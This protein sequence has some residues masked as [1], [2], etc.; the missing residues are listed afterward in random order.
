METRTRIKKAQRLAAIERQQQTVRTLTGL[1][2]QQYKQEIFDFG[3]HFLK[4]L[5]DQD[6]EMILLFSTCPKYWLWF[7]A[8]WNNWQRELL[9]F[10]QDHHIDMTYEFWVSETMPLIHDRVTE[11]GFKNYLKIFHNIRL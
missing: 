7:R 3:M 2:D 11:E 9:Q 6:E 5:F 10:V 1:S 8:E 4:T